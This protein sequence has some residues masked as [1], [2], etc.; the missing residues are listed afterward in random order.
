VKVEGAPVTSFLSANT[1][2]GRSLGLGGSVLV[3]KIGMLQQIAASGSASYGFT[4]A[5]QHNV[6]I[7]L[8]AGYYQFRVNPDGAVV[9]D[10]NDVIVNG[11]TQSA[12]SINS[13]VG[14]LYQFKGFEASIASRQVIQSFSNFGYSGLDGY[15][16]KRHM[17]G[18]MAYK[19]NLNKS[20]SLKPLVMYKGINNVG[21]LDFN[22]DL[23][24]KNMFFG[25][26]GYRTKVGLIGRVGM[27]I[28][29]LFF[30]GY[31]YESPMQ[32]MAKY[33]SGSHELILGLKLCS[34]NK[35]LIDST[36]VAVVPDPIVDTV[37]QTIVDT[38]IVERVD[39]VYIETKAVTDKE[40]DRV[41]DLAAKKLEFE[42]DKSIIR[43]SS[44]GELESLVNIMSVRKDLN[45]K[46]EGHTDDKGST[47]YNMGLSRNRVLAVK[48]FL[49]ANGIEG[50]RIQ[51]EYFG[52]TRPIT[53]NDTEAGREKNRRVEMYFLK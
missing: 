43:K 37:Y 32:N 48:E 6:R 47:D 18:F 9:F 52:E 33:S 10:G 40:A 19:F 11:G 34:K 8:T 14:L 30:I 45:I 27:N 35:P 17:M 28:R 41:V 24:Y 26:L 51:I 46:L 15:G 53:S 38:L 31:A 20:L 22:A 1:R 2:I 29:D 21:Q 36:D 7:G 4:F 12:S 13:E 39:T 44:Y 5:K 49:I 16:L 50:S 3:D 42:N 25:G 23:G